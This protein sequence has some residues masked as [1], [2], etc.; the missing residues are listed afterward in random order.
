MFS[1]LRKGIAHLVGLSAVL[2]NASPLRIIPEK[3]GAERLFARRIQGP[4]LRADVKVKIQSNLPGIIASTLQRVQL[5]PLKFPNAFR[6]VILMLERKII[7]FRAN[8]R[9][10]LGGITS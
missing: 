7:G 6:E 5:S 4:G 8:N 9:A 2:G 10:I 1:N 3:V